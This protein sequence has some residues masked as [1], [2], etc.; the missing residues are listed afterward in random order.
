MPPGRPII[1]DCDSESYKVAEYIDQ[2]LQEIRT[3]L[4]KSVHD[5]MGKYSPGEM[6]SKTNNV[7]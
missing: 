1:S 7:L 4:C 3:Q 5:T 6:L 2:F